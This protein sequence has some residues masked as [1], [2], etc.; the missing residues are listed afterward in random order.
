MVLYAGPTN[1]PLAGLTF[2]T[3]GGVISSATFAE[4]VSEK[5]LIFPVVSITLS[6]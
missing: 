3:S 1:D 5:S 6:L 2:I 4:T